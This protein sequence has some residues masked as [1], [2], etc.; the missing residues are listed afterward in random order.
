MIDRDFKDSFAVKS[1]KVSQY[2]I[3]FMAPNG[4]KYFHVRLGP[5]SIICGYENLFE[6]KAE[7]T[8]KAISAVD[9][10]AIRK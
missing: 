5:Q 8:Y 4:N 2:C 1:Q 6:K 3:G 10:Y 9:A 7:Y